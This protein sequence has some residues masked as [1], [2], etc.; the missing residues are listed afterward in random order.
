MNV[1]A[2]FVN[3]DTVPYAHLIVSG[4]KLIETRT[5]NM[6]L[7]LVGERVAIV[8][9]RKGRPAM[10]VGYATVNSYSFCPVNMLDMWRQ[11]T[12]IPKGDTYDNLGKRNG[13]QGKWFYELYQA[14]SCKPYALPENTVR[15]GR[16]WCEW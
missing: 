8:S 11:E 6:L 13:R 7:P 15:H 12:M 10:V 14:E 16:S 9:T 2:M 5:K 3:E 4:K 1:K